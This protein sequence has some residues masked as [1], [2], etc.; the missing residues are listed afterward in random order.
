MTLAEDH[1]DV[2]RAP[3]RERIVVILPDLHAVPIA[4][5]ADPATAEILVSDRHL[6]LLR[7]VGGWFVSI[8]ELGRGSPGEAVA[9]VHPAVGIAL[10]EDDP[11]EH[12]PALGVDRDG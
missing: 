7:P 1:L 3:D 12:V 4:G 10:R 5:N 11:V 2:G 6:H 9:A 8:Q